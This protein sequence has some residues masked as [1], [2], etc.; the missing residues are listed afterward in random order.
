M[1][2]REDE[3]D[4][5]ARRLAEDK[6]RLDKLGQEADDLEKEVEGDKPPPNQGWKGDVAP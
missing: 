3:A 1:T 4:A 6:A 2:D 5:A